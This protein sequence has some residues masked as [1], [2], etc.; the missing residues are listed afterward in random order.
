FTL[1][2]S[3][4]LQNSPSLQKALLAACT[5]AFCC[6]L[7]E[8]LVQAT[9]SSQSGA[10]PCRQPDVPGWEFGSHVSMPLQNWLSLQKEL[11]GVWMHPPAG[12]QLS[13]VQSIPSSHER[14]VPMRH[15]TIG[16]QDSTPL[17]T[18]PSLHEVGV[19]TQLSVVM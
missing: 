11:S 17:Q 6:G 1:Q 3:V 14:S 2:D 7:H 10:A 18:F 15:P 19:C 13:W 5:Q 12:S 8:S 4:P 9:S 16:S